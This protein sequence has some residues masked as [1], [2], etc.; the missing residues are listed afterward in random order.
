M[1]SLGA[2]DT[3]FASELVI[4]YSKISHGNLVFTCLHIGCLGSG[5][6]E[7]FG[8]DKTMADTF[9]INGG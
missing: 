8:M 4:R 2:I 6:A 5:M 7:Y 1:E 9:R 3:I